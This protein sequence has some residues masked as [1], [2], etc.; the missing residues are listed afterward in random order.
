MSEVARRVLDSVQRR[1]APAP[2]QPTGPGTAEQPL[3]VDVRLPGPALDAHADDLAVAL[4]EHLSALLREL[5]LRRDLEVTTRPAAPGSTAAAVSVEQRPVAHLPADHLQPGVATETL[6]Q[7]IVRR[8]LRRLPLL[9]GSRVGATSTAAYLMSL[10]CRP[11]DASGSYFDVDTAERLLDDRGDE[12]VV[13]EVAASTLRRVQAG[14]ARAMVAF[15]EAEFHTSGMVYPD[16]R[17]VPT[18]GPPGSVRLR[19]NDV[20]LPERRLD[21]DAGWTAVVGHVREELSCR[22]HWFVRT[23]DVARVLDEDLLHIFPDLVAVTEANYSRARVTA[24]LRE[25]VRSGRRIR[26]LPGIMWLLIEAGGASAG[27][28]VLRMSESPLLP[29]ARYRPPA[30]GD[31]ILQAVRVRKLAAEEDWRL[32]VRG[33]PQ[34]AVRLDADIEQRLAGE[35]GP[36]ARA[37]AEWAAVRALATAPGPQRVVTRTVDAVGPVRDALQAIRDVGRVMASHELPP[38]ADVDALPVLTDPGDRS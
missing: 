37:R 11:G 4:R 26:N 2:Q 14:D 28:D 12:A 6:A 17:V 36:V 34:H 38:D 32:G 13:L 10:G 18:D 5:R 15:R 30:P 31:P 1:L 24:C 23:R 22:R 20:T 16:V 8:T 29:K 25:L 21:P 27:P 7:E 9:A 3:R 33:T 19:L 35:C